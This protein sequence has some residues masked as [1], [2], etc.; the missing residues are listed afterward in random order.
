MKIVLNVRQVLWNYQ[1][2]SS[3]PDWLILVNVHQLSVTPR[4]MR[5]MNF[6]INLIRVYWAYKILWNFYYWY[7]CK[8]ADTFHV[9]KRSTMRCVDT[10][11]A[12]NCERI[13]NL[14]VVKRSLH[15]LGGSMEWKKEK[16]MTIISKLIP[17]RNVQ[18]ITVVLSIETHYWWIFLVSKL[19]CLTVINAFLPFNPSSHLLHFNHIF[20]DKNLSSI[21]IQ[22]N[23]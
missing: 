7:V 17:R 2:S 11:Q 5:I 16:T 21:R 12:T 13:F 1:R 20:T 19:F 8:V 9:R 18:M 23:F 22:I 3:Y 10:S 14:R 4:Y 15:F 6:I